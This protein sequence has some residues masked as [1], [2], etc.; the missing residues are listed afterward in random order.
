MSLL[1]PVWNSLKQ[2]FALAVQT[3][4]TAKQKSRIITTTITRNANWDKD[5]ENLIRLTKTEKI[6]SNAGKDVEKQVISHPLGETVGCQNF[7]ESSLA[8]I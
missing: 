2:V 6:P 4:V 3:Q 5:S 1:F 7:L 8:H